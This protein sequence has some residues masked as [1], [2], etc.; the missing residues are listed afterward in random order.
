VRT[1]CHDRPPILLENTGTAPHVQGIYIQSLKPAAD[2]VI[3]G[4]TGTQ[5]C[6]RLGSSFDRRASSSQ[7]AGRKPTSAAV[8][9]QGRHL[10]LASS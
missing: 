9:G 4:T 7:P 10:K 8:W 1:G 5:T 2:R 6:D 3:N